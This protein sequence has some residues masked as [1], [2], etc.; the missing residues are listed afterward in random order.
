MRLWKRK[1]EFSALYREHA[2]EV[3]AWFR[4]RTGSHE[5]AA[6]LTAETFARGLERYWRVRGSG[7]EGAAIA[8]IFGIAQ[9]VL[10][11]HARSNRIQRSVAARLGMTLE[12]AVVADDIEARLER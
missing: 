11:E 9:N 12:S 6:D 5:T 1:P 10:R 8:W 4:K 2:R 7:G 3:Y